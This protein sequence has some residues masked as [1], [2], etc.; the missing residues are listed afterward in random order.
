MNGDQLE[1]GQYAVSTSNRNFEGRQGAGGRTFLASP[2]DRRRR[3]GRGSHHRP[4]RADGRNH[5]TASAH[6]SSR[7]VVLPLENIDTDQIIPARFLKATTQDR[8]RQAAVRRLALRRRRAAEARISCSTAP[9]RRGRAVLVAG[10]N[11][12][13]GS[14]R[15]HA[16]W[17]LLDYGFRAVVSTSI[18][19]IFRNNAL[20]NGLLPVVVD[21]RGARVAPGRT[22][23][24]E[25][26][27]SLERQTLTLADGTKATV[28]HRPFARYCLMNGVD[29]L[30]FLL[31]QES[32]IAGVRGAPRLGEP[33]AELVTFPVGVAII[34]GSVARTRRGR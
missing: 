25:V 2:L 24:A 14:S 31:M 3:R 30:E 22:P 9:R 34:E 27:I 4:A 10:D 16:P 17:A 5:G 7:T 19:D 32:A 6:L 11:F 1:P 29:E 13:C 23:G 28:P 18:A 26:T 8:A 20:K 33:Y 15:E 21:A 12:G